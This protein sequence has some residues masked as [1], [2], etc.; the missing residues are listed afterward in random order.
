MV[1][2]LDFG[3]CKQ[4][5]TDQTR[6]GLTS[7]GMGTYYYLPPEA[8]YETGSEVSCKLDV[9]SVG[10]I[11]YELLYG[12]KP[13]GNGIPQRQIYNEGIILKAIKVEFPAQTPLKYK[14]S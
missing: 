11:F 3:L 7:A 8:F 5:E 2:I 13:F 4:M 14:V 1:K 6:M 12:I 9:W 10:V